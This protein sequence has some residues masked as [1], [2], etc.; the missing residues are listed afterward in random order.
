MPN[1]GS[2]GCDKLPFTPFREGAVPPDVCS[3]LIILKSQGLLGGTADPSHAKW[4]NN[5]PQKLVFKENPGEQW[6]EQVIG[7]TSSTKNTMLFQCFSGKGR[8][9]YTG[10]C[11]RRF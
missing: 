4:W 1:L 8:S 9:T 7:G 3:Q 10:Q 11:F 5:G 6:V 2:N